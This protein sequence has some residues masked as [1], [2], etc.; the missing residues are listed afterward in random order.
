MFT[1]PFR[2]KGNLYNVQSGKLIERA[3][4]VTFGIHTELAGK[5]L[6]RAINFNEAISTL[7]IKM[8]KGEEMVI[9]LVNFH[10]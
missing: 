6:G 5:R 7:V 8:A 4:F 2:E 1:K 3:V 9:G 10:N